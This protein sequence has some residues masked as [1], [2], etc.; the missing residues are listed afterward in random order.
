ML[1]HEDEKL[2]RLIALIREGTSTGGLS[3]ELEDF[4]KNQ[5]G[6]ALGLSEVG[7]I[8]DLVR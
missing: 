5:V 6:S 2:L 8:I 1:E 3:S 7:Q 4:L